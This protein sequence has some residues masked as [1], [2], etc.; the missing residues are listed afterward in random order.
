M[1]AV[2]EESD[3]QRSVRVRS[4]IRPLNAAV[5]PLALGKRAAIWNDVA[6]RSQL[7][8]SDF[9]IAL[10]VPERMVRYLAMSKEWRKPAIESEGGSYARKHCI[11]PL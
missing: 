4:C 3:Y 6:A 1:P 2:Q 10:D 9:R 8:Y 7:P 11:E 5:W